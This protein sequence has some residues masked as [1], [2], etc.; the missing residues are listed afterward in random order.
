MNEAGP[1]NQNQ[2]L[3]NAK[4]GPKVQ[5]EA[6]LEP[7]VEGARR[8]SPP[9]GSPPA[10]ALPITVLPLV[11]ALQL[12][13]VALL[14]S[15]LL[16]SGLSGALRGA[17]VGAESTILLTDHAAA[18]TSQVAAICTTLLLIYV[19][20][21]SARSCR[22]LIIGAG[23]ALLGVVPTLLVFYAH[24][25]SLPHFYTWASAL[26]AGATL[27]LGASQARGNSLVRT[28]LA[29]SGLTL[30]A[31]V[32]RTS[33]LSE[34][35][36]PLL[37]RV[38]AGLELSF[39]WLT[40]LAV[41]ALHLSSPRVKPLRGALLFGLALLLARTAS[42]SVEPSAP[43]WLLLSGRALSELTSS[44][45][46]GSSA[47]LAFSVSIL[48][49]LSALFSRPSSFSEVVCGVLALCAVSPLS[50]LTI[51]SMTLCGYCLVVLC[52]AKTDAWLSTSG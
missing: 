22:S 44:S 51:A 24:R 40:I 17:Y 35:P 15:L 23:S 34:Q 39:A 13:V 18:L 1:S 38:G 8:S 32:L 19:G 36:S 7:R 3:T 30:L 46:L 5:S 10:P 29:F 37:V 49:L 50:P 9:L 47:A 52:W 28:I 4:Q 45:P 12:W 41:T 26:C 2:S 25:F 42:A 21:M 48:V 14:T 11:W 33:E 43:P 31:A 6:Q 20:L 27:L 16:S